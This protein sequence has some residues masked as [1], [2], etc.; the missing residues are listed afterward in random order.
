MRRPVT[1]TRVTPIPSGMAGMA[2][3]AAVA[4]AALMVMAALPARAVEPTQ[5]AEPG[6]WSAWHGCWQPVGEDAPVGALVCVAPGAD[7]SS[8]RLITLEDGAIVGESV[9]HADG[10]AREVAEGGCT[11][12][13]TAHWSRDGRRVFT[14]TDLEC[15]GV[16]RTSTGVMALIAENEWIDAQAV[17]VAGQHAARAVRYRSVR[18]ANLPEAATAFAV[19]PSLGQEAARLNAAR[20]LDIDAVVEASA[21]V[22]EP[23]LE[24]L[25]AARQHGFRLDGRTLVELERQGVPASVMDMMIAL[26][27]PRVFA[28]QQQGGGTVAADDRWPAATSRRAMASRC[29]DPWYASSRDGRWECDRYGMGYGYRSYGY[30]RYGYSPFGYDPYGWNYGRGPI[31]VI[32]RPDD[33]ARSGGAVVPGQGYTRGD[34]QPSGRQATP[35]GTRQQP[36]ASGSSSGSSSSTAQPSRNGTSTGRQAVPRPSNNSGND[37]EGQGG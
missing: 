26:S 15:D 30:G 24:A 28:V 7:A 22:A 13:E 32:V 1:S 21:A 20:P 8:I 6:N 18:T 36:S 14:R 17:A 3:V 11:G 16:R 5:T 25:L 29:A 4:A 31:V 10:T 9:L 2:A 33:S 27:H 34:A 37:P 35:R 12:T 23:A 19:E